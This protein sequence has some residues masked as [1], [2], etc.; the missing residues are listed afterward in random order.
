MMVLVTYDVSFDDVDGKRRLRKL[1]KACLDYGVRVQYSVF[2]CD[3]APDQWVKFKALLL[4]IYDPDV[5]SL[6]FY[7]LGKNWR[8]RV[9]H[10]GAKVA[11][12]IFQ[13]ALIL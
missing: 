5:D 11:V 8:N 9:E 10:H 6:R 4:S 1:A 2:E 7:K 13:D 12:D 3:I